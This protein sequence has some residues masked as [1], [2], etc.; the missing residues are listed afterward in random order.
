MALTP[1]GRFV[2]GGYVAGS[3]SSNM[4]VLRSTADGSPDTSFGGDGAIVRNVSDGAE[5][6]TDVLV[7]SS[8]RIYAAGQAESVAVPRFA[9]LK[10]LS[11]GAPDPSFSRDG[12]ALVN[13]SEGGDVAN[14]I[15]RRPDG[16]VVLAGRAA[17]GGDQNI[18]VVRLTASGA[19]DQGF[20]LDGIR[21][22]PSAG[23]QDEAFAVR[24]AGGGLWIAGRIWGS[25]QDLT[26]LR[27]R[28][29]GGND[30]SFSGDGVARLDAFGGADAARALALA[31]GAVVIAGEAER[32]GTVRM[33]AARVLA[34]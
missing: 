30:R 15:A 10:L 27:L 33:V 7:A 21:I 1:G 22:V 6:V 2:L 8:G 13:V 16:S 24:A 23:A 20:H 19:L 5:Q 32:D 26:L 4:F 29:G 31:D 28:A 17:D 12:V 18:A 3:S 9:A 14:A 25:G 34:P 11:S